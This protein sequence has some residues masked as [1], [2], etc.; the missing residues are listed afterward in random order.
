M[1]LFL[2][3][4]VSPKLTVIQRGV[5]TSRGLA[6]SGSA[7]HE[8]LLA[9]SRRADYGYLLSRACGEEDVLHEQ[10]VGRVSEHSFRSK[11][12]PGWQSKASQIL[13]RGLKAPPP[14]FGGGAAVC[15][16]RYLDIS[17]A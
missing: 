7:L 10:P 11:I 9:R 6:V 16:R 4:C 1:V 17:V 8:R 2:F 15:K 5:R 14:D 12:S 13:S 3:V